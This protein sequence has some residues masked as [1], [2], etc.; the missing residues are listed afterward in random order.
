MDVFGFYFSSLTP[1]EHSLTIAC[2]SHAL[3]TDDVPGSWPSEDCGVSSHPLT[4]LLAPALHDVW[5]R[6][7]SR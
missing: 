3:I 2:Y 4:W 1:A 6:S 5:E 7:V